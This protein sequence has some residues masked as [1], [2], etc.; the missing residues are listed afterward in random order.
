MSNFFLCFNLTL[1]KRSNAKI[2]LLII[3]LCSHYYTIIF[4]VS[5]INNF[6]KQKS[7]W[8]YFAYIIIY[9]Y[10]YLYVHIYIY[11][12]FYMNNFLPSRNIC[13]FF[14][15]SNAYENMLLIYF[16]YRDKSFRDIGET[17]LDT[18]C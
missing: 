10:I 16:V 3:F 14:L 6:T 8:T 15:S 13:S 12:Y 4:L 17:T 1:C 7:I 11:I 18:G 2:I 9:N 5:N